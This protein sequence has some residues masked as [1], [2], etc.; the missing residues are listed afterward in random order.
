MKRPVVALTMGDPGGIGPEI[1]A[2]CFQNFKG[3]RDLFYVLFGSSSV[4]E[5]LQLR[6]GYK[7]PLHPIEDLRPSSLRTQC[8]NFWDTPIFFRSADIGKVSLHNATLA[9][10]ALKLAA[11][12]AVR[13]QVQAIVTAPVHKTAMR[14]VAPGF[15]GHTEFL[16]R[17]AKARRYA[18]MFVGPKLKVTLVTIH[19]PISKVSRLITRRLVHEKIV[20]THDFLKKYFRR[21]HPKIAVCALNPHGRETGSED[22]AEIRPAVLRARR[23]GIRAEGP[24]SADQ[25][26][27]DAYE[28]RYDAVVSMY[29][30]QGLAPFKMIAFKEGVN[31]TLGL[32]FIRTSPDHGTAFDIAYQGKADPA[33]FQAALRLAERLVLKR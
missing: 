25:L 3:R 27:Y 19:V 24:F 10:A 9:Y 20:L 28:G 22:E 17:A 26:F 13:N 32:P 18:M 33:S 8:I 12:A 6:F 23:Q 1:I 2:R 5:F 16:A 7:L 29:H 15:H 21:P 14:L 31:V 11:E 30:D 4:F